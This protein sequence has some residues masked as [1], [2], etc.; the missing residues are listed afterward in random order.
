[1]SA[2]RKHVFDPSRAILRGMAW[3]C[4]GLVA[5]YAVACSMAWLLPT[6]AQT[7]ST[8]N[9]S[10]GVV[11]ARYVL[12]SDDSILIDWYSMLGGERP[13]Y[14]E[15]YGWPIRSWSVWHRPLKGGSWSLIAGMPLHQARAP[16]VAAAEPPWA[17]PIIPRVPH[18]AASAAIYAMVGF[19][20][21][22]GF[23]CA[24]TRRRVSRGCCG[25]CGY[26]PWN[27][28]DQCPECGMVRAAANSV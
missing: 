5:S 19:V 1:M 2:R 6:R 3:L 12:R 9:Q 26:G 10:G 14:A 28:G 17:L 16:A 4:F 15:D 25:D 7:R 24:R 21:W 27:S 13:V 8:I 11:S 22:R 18:I 23:R 20:G